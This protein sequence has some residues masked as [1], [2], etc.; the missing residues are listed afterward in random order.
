MPAALQ[1][2]V[3]MQDSRPS[4]KGRQAGRACRSAAS[5][6]A[7]TQRR[8]LILGARCRTAAP[9]ARRC[10]CAAACLRHAAKCLCSRRLVCRS[11]SAHATRDPL[12]FLR[13]CVIYARQRCRAATCEAQY[14]EIVSLPL[15]RACCARVS[16]CRAEATSRRRQQCSHGQLHIASQSV[17]CNINCS[18]ITPIMLWGRVAANLRALPGGGSLPPAPCSALG[19]H[20]PPRAQRALRPAPGPVPLRA[21]PEP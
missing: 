14:W 1:I 19:G 8:S 16:S 13:R 4:R 17:C 6:H 3:S 21:P 12:A 2:Y 11:A 9:A 5:R 7:Q 15:S 18:S 10:A 20:R